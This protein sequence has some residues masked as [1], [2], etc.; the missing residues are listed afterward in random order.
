MKLPRPAL[1]ALAMLLVI[2]LLRAGPLAM[3]DDAAFR[4]QAVD[5]LVARIGET[6][7]TS[8]QTEDWRRRYGQATTNIDDLRKALLVGGKINNDPIAPFKAQL[9]EL[10]TERYE[11][12]TFLHGT[13]LQL[14]K[15]SKAAR[16]QAVRDVGGA[17]MRFLT[18]K[19]GLGTLANAA[20][21]KDAEVIKRDFAEI[22]STEQAIKIIRGY[23][24]DMKKNMNDLKARR[25]E[26]A[27]VHAAFK[28]LMGGGEGS[29]MGKVMWEN[30][31]GKRA[32]EGSFKF[33]VTGQQL[34]GDFSVMDGK[35]GDEI[36]MKRSGEVNGKVNPD[37]SI[38]AD[39]KGSSTCV[40]KCDGDIASIVK[41]LL[42]F[43]F[44]GKLEG[45]VD[46]NQA[47]GKYNV[48][49]TDQRQKP[50]TSNGT[51]SATRQG[52]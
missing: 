36:R 32:Y 20:R 45:R 11:Y 37:G 2:S 49:S 5:G 26:L 52:G 1:H 24:E 41:S 46:G 34:K 38:D 12:W 47:G 18:P 22:R 15:Q 42:G 40:G 39:I 30:Q 33:L 23:I 29:F 6:I 4:Q 17:M 50:V 8:L 13:L 3:A 31:D 21:T 43:P 9:D 7:G 14:L 44:R 19:P 48:H 16:E 35:A 28:A 10:W 27:P 51:W 25:E